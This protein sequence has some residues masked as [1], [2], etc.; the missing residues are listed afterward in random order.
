M[1]YSD[2]LKAVDDNDLKVSLDYLASY[3][4]SIPKVE[5]S[6][7]SD[8]SEFVDD[9]VS[10][11]RKIESL[12]EEQKSALMRSLKHVVKEIGELNLEKVLEESRVVNHGTHFENG[13]YWLFD[14][15][16]YVPCE[17]HYQFVLDNQD[18]FVEKLGM[19]TWKTM[20]A[21]HTGD[22][23][24]MRLVLSSGGVLVQIYKTGKVRRAKYQCCQCSLGWVKKKITK[25]PIVT[26]LIRVYDPSKEYSGFEDGIKFI[27]KK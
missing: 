7:V 26:S 24:L 23:E 10:F 9:I 20:R 27:I 12:S 17:D 4:L 15:G 5:R 8:L 19:D 2:L 25:M 18:L 16:A 14:D 11:R 13:M 3:W 21:R 22:G 6:S 1:K